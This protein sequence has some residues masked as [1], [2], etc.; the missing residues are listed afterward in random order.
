MTPATERLRT[1]RRLYGQRGDRWDG[2]DLAF[3]IYATLL[4]AAIVAFPL[5]RAIVVELARPGVIDILQAPQAPIVV[6][7]LS[8]AVLA[9]LAWFGQL[10][11]PVTPQ[12]FFVTLLA[13]TDLPRGLTLRRP[14]GTS[15]ALVTAI[16]TAVGLLF[17]GVLVAAGA[18]TAGRAAV[19]LLGCVSLGLI[20]SVMWLVGQRFRSRLLWGVLVA[21]LGIAALSGLHPAVAGIFPWGWMGVL[22]PAGAGTGIGAATVWSVAALAALAVLAV[23][24]LWCVPRLLRTLDGVQ[25]MDDAVRWQAATTA[26]VSG[27]VARALGSFRARPTIGRAWNAVAGRWAAL[28]YLRRDLVATVR[29]P[30]RFTVAALGLA[31]GC[32]AAGFSLSVDPSVAWLPAAAGAA[33]GF[34]ALGVFSDGFR[35][36][37]QASAAAALYG[38]NTGR[39]YRLHALLPAGLAAVA[40]LAAALCVLV[41]GAPARGLIVVVLLAPVLLLVRA[42]DSAKGDLPILLLTPVPTPG[43]D[44]SGLSVLAWQAD[45]LLIA[46]GSGAL[47]AAMVGSGLIAPAVVVSSAA[48]VALV[49]L[50][51]RRLR[52]L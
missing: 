52:N 22:W 25:L 1:L 3:G 43:G 8:A 20:G 17:A 11:G 18:A 38:Y 29:T 32:I 49:V 45:A 46:T 40:A 33:M 47:L 19:F 51:H 34:L 36:A 30:G 26:A 48:V 5:I 23:A 24:G 35:H 50:L 31:A 37:A 14:F 4:I 42:Y 27:D 41:V 16:S 9:A 10:R 39:L 2:R 21:L 12:P 28:R 13:T 44:L 15:A 7:A 6:G